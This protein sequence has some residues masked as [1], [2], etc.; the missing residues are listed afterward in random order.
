[1]KRAGRPDLL[2][3][4]LPKVLLEPFLH[5]LAV[6]GRGAVLL[7]DVMVISRYPSASFDTIL[8]N[9]F[10][11][12]HLLHPGGGG[13]DL[14]RSLVMSL[15]RLAIIAVIFLPVKTASADPPEA[16]HFSNFLSTS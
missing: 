1:M 12:V 15:S 7:E 10:W 16:I 6:V 4:H 5:P 13:V 11:N 14:A 3:L 8:S 2:L 9:L